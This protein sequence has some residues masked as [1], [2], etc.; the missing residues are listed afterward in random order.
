MIY[1]LAPWLYN[2]LQDLLH[3]RDL[4]FQD[5]CLCGDKYASELYLWSIEFQN[6]HIIYAKKCD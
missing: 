1:Y 4:Q 2:L 5:Q 6:Y 3:A